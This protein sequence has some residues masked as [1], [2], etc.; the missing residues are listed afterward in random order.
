ML[1]L[2]E[3]LRQPRLQG[4][5]SCP[6]QQLYRHLRRELQIQL[7]GEARGQRE[8]ELGQLGR[9]RRGRL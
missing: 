6:V 2:Y 8:P 3:A 9:Q 5:M 4:R 1:F 7:E